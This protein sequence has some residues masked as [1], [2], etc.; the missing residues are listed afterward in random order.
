VQKVLKGLRPYLLFAGFFS[1]A[2]NLL[3]LAPPLYML[4]VFDRVLTS[5]SNETLVALTLAA[6]IALLAMAA[7]DMVR[8]YLLSAIGAAIDRMVGPKVLDSLLG[9]AARLG[10]REHAYALRDVSALRSFFSGA[11]I[12]ALFDAPWLPVF[13]LII[14][15]FHP[16]L[17]ALAFAGSMAMLVLAFLNERLTRAPLERVQ[18]EG[19]RASRFIDTAVRNAE[20]VHALGMLPAVTARWS[21]FNEAAL[22]EQGK[23]TRAGAAVSSA[24][25]FARQFIQTAMLAAGAYVVIDQQVS[26]GVMMAATILL[27]RALAPVE[28]LVAGWRNLVEARGAWRRLDAL[29]ASREEAQPATAL[30]APQGRL[31][32]ERVVFGVKGSDRP[33]I[34][35]ASFSLAAGEALGIVGPSASGKSTL[36]RLIVGV[37]RPSAGTV[38]LDGADVASWA[39]EDLGRHIG[40]LPQEVDLFPGTVT[41]NIARLGEP[42]DAGVIRAAQRAHVHELVLRLPNG[43]DTEIGERFALSPG[44]RQR[45]ALA[46]AL[47]GN[48]RLVVLDEPNANLDSEGE[49]ALLAAL[50]GL[51]EDGVTVVV[52][53][54]RPSLLVGV[55]KVL[56]LREGSVEALG[57]RGEILQRVVRRAA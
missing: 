3:L 36:A 56:V 19:R 52:V 9:H 51:K 11:G 38:R 55:D 42:D 46:R 18:A 53:A 24:T 41:Q 48:P 17:G 30:P 43:Y 45:I 20:V 2:M 27:G 4:Q 37:W 14:T 26:A 28:Q 39:R 34:R 21:R 5:R 54:H 35:G 12:L 31:D 7:L 23:A 50:R 25:K 22:A 6:G 40:Y 57:P 15:L 8:A 44:Q 1:L 32:A 13:L 49:Q 29:F 33:I 47:Y 16:L 10:A